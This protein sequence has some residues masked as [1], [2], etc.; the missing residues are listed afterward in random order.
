MVDTACQP[1]R[2]SRREIG[3]KIY[4]KVH[5]YIGLVIGLIFVVVGLSGSFLAFWQDIDELLN[6]DLMTVSV[7]A[8]PQAIYRPLD[9]ILSAA[10]VAMPPSATPIGIRLPRHP[11]A[12]ALIGYTVPAEQQQKDFFIVF[13]DPYTAKVTGQRLQQRGDDPF[14]QPFI[15]QVMSL[16]SNLLLGYARCYVVGI[17]GIVLFVSVVAGLLLWWPRNG[18][19]RQS[20][21]IKQGASAERLTYDVHKVFGV[22]PCLVLIV[23]LF[24]GIYMIFKPQVR[25]VVQLFSPVREMPMD[26]KSVPV[27]EREPLGIGAAVA[28]ADRIFPDGRLQSIRLPAG[29]EG[30]YVVGKRTDD[31]VNQAD[32]KRVVAIHQYSGELLYV[33]DPHEFSA[34]EKFLE[35]QY[36]LHSGEAFGNIGRSAILV[37]GFV[38]LILYVTGVIRWLHKRRK[39]VRSTGNRDFSMQEGNGRAGRSGP[40]NTLWGTGRFRCWSGMDR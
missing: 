11:G 34:G 39:R 16:H 7:P 37:T 13:V 4:L 26:L 5:Q 23:L 1:K 27:A 15:Y 21:T 40:S 3:R 25:A 31:E 20:L 9:D 19:W 30:I 35:W 17:S 29:K 18:K 36:P 33:Q 28:I 6:P 38:P 10:R 14:T 8:Q 24:S 2:S 22:Y 32:T 12:T